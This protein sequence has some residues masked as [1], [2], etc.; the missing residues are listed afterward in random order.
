[1]VDGARDAVALLHV[2]LWEEGGAGVIDNTG[3]RDVAHCRGFHHVAHNKA[4][5]CFVLW[6]QSAAVDAV[7]W[8]GVASA[9][10]ASAVVASLR[11]HFDEKRSKRQKE[12]TT[13]YN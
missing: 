9:H 6:A 4:L 1:M 3:V 11:W 2:D 13:S 5:H 12:N 10:F 8:L 7:D